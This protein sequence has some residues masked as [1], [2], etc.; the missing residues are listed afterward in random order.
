MLEVYNQNNTTAKA[1]VARYLVQFDQ[2]DINNF[3]SNKNATES[4]NFNFKNYIAFGQGFNID[5][6]LEIY[7]VS[8]SW[9]N[10]TGTF[11]DSPEVTNGVSWK[12]RNYKDGKLW[13]FNS[14][15]YTT[16][17]FFSSSAVEGGG[18]WFTGSLDGK[19]LE[20]TQ[21]FSLRSKKDINVDVTDIGLIWYS[22]SNSIG[23]DTLIYNNGFIVKQENRIEFSTASSEQPVTKY[24][25]IDTNTIYPPELQLRWDDYNNIT[26]PN[27]QTI[28]DVSEVYFTEL[29]ES[30]NEYNQ[31][32][33]QRF[34]INIK[35][36]YPIRTYQTASNY[37][38]NYYLPEESTYSI[39]DLDTNE[40]VIDFNDVYTKI[41]RDTV[42]NYFDIYMN[43]LEPERYYE[44]LLKVNHN[45]QVKIINDKLYFKVI[46]G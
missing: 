29:R 2:D 42:S 45:N 20:V 6:N 30:K 15:P 9:E 26:N 38:T 25:S 32:S 14:N 4:I 46:N 40:T 33:V 21:S 24:F 34:R 36:K 7:P 22:S 19:K 11:A 23:N 28:T 12:W 41:S 17:S 43:G 37:I 39:K 5:T 10:G 16:Q 35:P 3:I 31:D 27:I 8:G 18:V 44:I 1:Q 13:N